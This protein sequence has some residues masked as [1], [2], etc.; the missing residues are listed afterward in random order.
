MV[1]L[2]NETRVVPLWEASGQEWPIAAGDVL[3]DNRRGGTP[4]RVKAC[5]PLMNRMRRE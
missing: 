3:C 4:S 2:S 5:Q 1:D